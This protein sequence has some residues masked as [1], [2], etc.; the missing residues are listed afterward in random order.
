L[1]LRFSSATREAACTSTGSCTVPEVVS[2]VI[3]WY[4]FCPLDDVMGTPIC[5]CES[6]PV[7]DCSAEYADDNV[8]M[9]VDAYGPFGDACST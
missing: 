7:D 3:I 8:G 4:T 6:W 5:R 1:R 2:K 9:E